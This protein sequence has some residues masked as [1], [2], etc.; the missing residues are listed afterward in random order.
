ML[1]KDSTAVSNQW[2]MPINF[3]GGAILFDL[4][5]TQ[6]KVRK[7]A[8]IRNRYNP[9]PHLTQDTNGKVTTSQL[10]IT[11]ESQYVSPFQAGDPKAS[12]NRQKHHTQNHNNYKTEI[13]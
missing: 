9:A 1:M 13:T 6:Y 2:C 12:I 7:R 4:W 8:K 5:F 11:N 3:L 10:D